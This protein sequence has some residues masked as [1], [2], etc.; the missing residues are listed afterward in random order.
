MEIRKLHK[1]KVDII[2]SE[3]EYEFIIL[4]IHMQLCL[5]MKK[6]KHREQKCF[7]R[8]FFVVRYV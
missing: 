8:F 6:E 5:P 2:C 3:A 1:N 4:D 7:L